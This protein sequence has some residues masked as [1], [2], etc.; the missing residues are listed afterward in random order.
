MTIEIYLGTFEFAIYFVSIAAVLIGIFDL[1][2]I[3][4]LCKYLNLTPIAVIISAVGFLIAPVL[5]EV[6]GT[7]SKF[8]EVPLTMTPIPFIFAA[9]MVDRRIKRHDSHNKSL[10]A[11]AG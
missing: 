2:N 11:D 9:S 5:A 10:N 7:Y 3:S 1:L 4:N 6:A 8:L